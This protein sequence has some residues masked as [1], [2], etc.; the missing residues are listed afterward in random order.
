MA[1]KK[2]GRIAIPFLL[3]FFIVLV[4]I[5]GATL[6]IYKSVSKNL[7]FGI[8][9]LSEPEPRDIAMATY[10]DSHTILFILDVPEETCSSTFVLMRSVPKD[11]KL[12]FVGVPTNTITV[13]NGAQSSMKEAY[14]RGGAIE[15]VSFAE[16]VFDIEIE[17]YMK[18]DSAALIRLCDIMGGVSY[19]TGVNIAGFRPADEEQLLVGKQVQTYLTYSM[20]SGGE[21]QRA[22][23]ASAVLSSMVNQADGQRIADDFDRNFNTII[24]MV[25][26]NVTAVDYKEHKAV[27][28]KMFE[29]GTSIARFRIMEGTESEGKF[30]PSGTFNETMKE[31]YFKT[32]SS[33]D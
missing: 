23:T 27:I 5:G 6:F 13:Y 21:V 9:E 29:R 7:G 26:T 14:D 31:E 8:K 19:T 16:Q 15:A 4:I 25:D 18:F 10:D 24:N 30:V 22:Y 33:S 11:K 3:T 1:K 2:N 28:K 32:E 12:L 17:R 20:F